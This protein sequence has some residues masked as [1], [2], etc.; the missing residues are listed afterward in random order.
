MMGGE[1]VS[2]P[3]KAPRENRTGGKPTGPPKVT[4]LGVE[5][6]SSDVPALNTAHRANTPY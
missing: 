5:P 4:L 3:F 1:E 6:N 2:V